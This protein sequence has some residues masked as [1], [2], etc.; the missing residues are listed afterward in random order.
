MNVWT[1]SWKRGCT[2]WKHWMNLIS[3]MYS[4]K[5]P[6]DRVILIYRAEP[7]TVS[8][9]CEWKYRISQHLER[10]KHCFHLPTPFSNVSIVF[11]TK[12]RSAP[13]LI[14][15]FFSCQGTPGISLEHLIK[16]GSEERSDLFNI[17]PVLLDAWAF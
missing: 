4:I 15:E 2:L 3:W 5:F 1:C 8:T 13:W 12:E 14:I 11:I 9:S 10:T 6:F 17:K 7:W 16:Q